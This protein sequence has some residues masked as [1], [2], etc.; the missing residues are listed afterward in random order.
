[1]DYYN[2]AEL[3]IYTCIIL[4]YEGDRT[5]VNDYATFYKHTRYEYE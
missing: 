1:M 2:D 5:V 4:W 3:L